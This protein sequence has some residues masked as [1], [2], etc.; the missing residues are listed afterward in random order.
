MHDCCVCIHFLHLGICHHGCVLIT[1]QLQTHTQVSSHHQCSLSG[2]MA[3]MLQ[4]LAVV[5][6]HVMHQ[7]HSSSNQLF[8]KCMI[9]NKSHN[10]LGCCNENFCSLDLH[11]AK[12]IWQ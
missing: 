3:S 8:R 4:C 2:M 10:L 6:S 12:S 5:C 7:M 1:G 9:Q 11:Q